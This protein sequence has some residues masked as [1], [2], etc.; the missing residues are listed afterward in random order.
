MSGIDQAFK[1]DSEQP[2]WGRIAEWTLGV[3]GFNKSYALVIGISKYA[4]GFQPFQS[5]SEDPIRIKEFLLDEAGFDYVHLLTEEKATKRRISTLIEEFFPDQVGENDRFLFY[6]SG[7]G[8]ETIDA[9]GR[10]LGYL[11]LADSGKRQFGSMIS[12]D[13]IARWDRRIRA[14][15]ALFL[16]DACFSGLAGIEAKSSLQDATIARLSK[17]AHHLITAGSGDEQAIAD[18]R[19]N[20]SLFTDTFIKGARGAADAQSD[21]VQDGVV[22]LAELMAY[23][24]Q[25]MD[26]ERL[27]VGWTGTITP[28]WN[29]LR[30]NQGEFFF[31]TDI[32]K[33]EMASLD[34]DVEI[35][36]DRPVVPMGPGASSPIDRKKTLA[37]TVPRDDLVRPPIKGH[38]KQRMALKTEPKLGAG[39]IKMLNTGELVD[40]D[41]LVSDRRWAKVVTRGH[42]D[43][44]VHLDGLNLIYKER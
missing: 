23:L 36:S 15:H 12:M 14:K 41:E 24:R 9:L 31:V 11:P 20:G 2:I 22:N 16:L 42:I 25:R 7:H 40:V 4:G 32:K 39:T 21:F 8:T 18:H 26:R 13:D 10:K 6:W 28:Q 27:Q 17:P 34:K 37:I 3:E 33:R 5:T 19:W 43:G 44:Y 30:S 35:E 29:H 38:L 1:K